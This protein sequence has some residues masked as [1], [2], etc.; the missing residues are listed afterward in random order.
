VRTIQPETG[1]T[2]ADVKAVIASRQFIFTDCFTI[3]APNG[4]KIRCCS[5]QQDVIVIPWGGGVKVTFTSKGVKVSGVRTVCQAG[6]EVDEQEAQIDFDTS[7][8]FQGISIPRAFM[9]G[10]FDGGS[11]TRDRYFA[12]SWGV[13]NAPTVWMGGTRM[14]AGKIADIDEIGRSYVKFKTRSDLGLLNINVPTT[15]FQPSCRNA[16]YDLG[17][18]LDR[19]AHQTNGFMGAGSTN[20]TINWTGALAKHALG[21]IYIVDV[22]GVTLVRTIR[23]VNPGVSLTL[24]YPLEVNPTAGQAFAVYE[25]CD[26]SYTRC[27]V[28]GNQANFRGYPFVPTEETAL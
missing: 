10:R 8:L 24:A 21:T 3:T 27:G 26:R 6:V 15:L 17:C 13:N 4:D 14:Y 1:F 22:S 19:T 25:G 7:M 16:I 12:Q 28:L 2:E 9:W 18:K 23:K 5:T 20:T 11:L